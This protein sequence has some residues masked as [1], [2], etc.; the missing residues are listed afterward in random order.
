MIRQTILK[1]TFSSSTDELDVSTQSFY[2]IFKNIL[3]IAALL[4]SHTAC[5]YRSLL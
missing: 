1:G 3:N 5:S 4:I 2:Y